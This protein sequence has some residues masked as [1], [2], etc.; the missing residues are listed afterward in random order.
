M[1]GHA[2]KGG[3]GGYGSYCLWVENGMLVSAMSD[4]EEMLLVS[5]MSDSE[6]MLLVS[7]MSDSE[8]MLLVSAINDSEEW[9]VSECNEW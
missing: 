2:L 5:A 4:S 3:G 9:D 6:E 1:G 8:E 7:A